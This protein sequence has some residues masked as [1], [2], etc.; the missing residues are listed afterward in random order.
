MTKNER[1]KRIAEMFSSFKLAKMLIDLQNKKENNN[2]EVNKNEENEKIKKIC[3][4]YSKEKLAEMIIELQSP[5]I[6]EDYELGM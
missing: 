6:Q 3:L 1:I 2:K 5:N 4:N